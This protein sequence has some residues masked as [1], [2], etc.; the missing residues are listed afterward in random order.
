MALQHQTMSRSAQRAYDDQAPDF[1][2]WERAEAVEARTVE[3]LEDRDAR[4]EIASDVLPFEL[5]G[6]WFTDATDAL[7]Q[8]DVKHP[9]DLLGSQ[10]LADMYRLA[11]IART[12]A[13][14]VA[15]ERAA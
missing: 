1:G 9:D 15:R 3:M 11:K 4:R 2:A 14:E 6:E 13:L 12:A 8:L 10:L 5:D 7:I